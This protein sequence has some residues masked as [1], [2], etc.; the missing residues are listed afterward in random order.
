MHFHLF[1]FRNVFLNFSTLSN[2]I[3]W[4]LE[5]NTLPLHY[6][7]TVNRQI[8]RG[9]YSRLRSL[10]CT[11]AFPP[12]SYT[13]SQPSYS[14]LTF[15]FSLFIYTVRVRK[16]TNLCFEYVC[17]SMARSR[18]LVCI[19]YSFSHFRVVLMNRRHS[20]QPLSTFKP[21]H[22]TD[23]YTRIPKVRIC[24]FQRRIRCIRV[25]WT[26]K[27]WRVIGILPF[28]QST[29]ERSEFILSTISK[30]WIAAT[31]SWRFDPITG[32]TR[33][34]PLSV[35]FHPRKLTAVWIRYHIS[36]KQWKRW[37]TIHP[38]CKSYSE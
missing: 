37:T 25:S 30:S 23:Q 36:V 33:F 21:S 12:L 11:I 32:G 29:F 24:Q 35:V 14:S 17:T 9:T 20:N 19:L 28:V 18:T 8:S 38:N 2:N 27:K 13:V 5:H 16:L 31:I 7:H 1:P 22:S 10:Q 15:V 26:E 4:L 3:P 6:N 34:K